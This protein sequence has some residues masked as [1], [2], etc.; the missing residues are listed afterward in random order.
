MAPHYRFPQSGSSLR[1]FSLIGFLVAISLSS[2]IVFAS[3]DLL[4]SAGRTVHDQEQLSVLVDDLRLLVTLLN[5]EVRDAGIDA[6]GKRIPEPFFTIDVAARGNTQ[7]F[8]VLRPQSNCLGEDHAA[9]TSVF[10]LV[11]RQFRCGNNNI[12]PINQT[13]VE[14][15]E[16]FRVLPLN[17]DGQVDWIHPVAFEI[18]LVFS[19]GRAPGLQRRWTSRIA[20]RNFLL[21]SIH[22][23]P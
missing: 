18:E 9:S 2:I 14:G 23:P 7:R 21:E 1:G 3:M 4:I 12:P 13:L 17:R 16:Q 5:R 11:Q 15:V 10:S 20:L 6:S 19:P 22:D 8:L